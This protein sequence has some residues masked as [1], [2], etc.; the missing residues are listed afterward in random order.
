[1]YIITYRQHYYE[2]KKSSFMIQ[3]LLL[4]IDTYTIYIYIYI[5]LISIFIL[6]VYL[7][8]YNETYVKHLFLN[9]I[10]KY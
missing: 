1:M 9:H 10:K 4:L 5:L 3:N 7:T 6:Y 8:I 2:S